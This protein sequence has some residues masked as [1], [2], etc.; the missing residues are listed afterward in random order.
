[1]LESAKLH[2]ES[3]R[4]PTYSTYKNHLDKIEGVR[5]S[6]TGVDKWADL[7]LDEVKMAEDIKHNLDGAK[8]KEEKEGLFRE[9]LGSKE[10]AKEFVLVDDIIDRV[11]YRVRNHISSKENYTILLSFCVVI[12]LYFIILLMQSDPA[13]SYSIESTLKNF[14]FT[15][16]SGT[17]E[18]DGSM[19]DSVDSGDDI[20]SW[21]QAIIAA[22]VASIHSIPM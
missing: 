17:A 15:P 9:K 18:Y 3:P 10:A 4:G 8:Y 6:S 11:R 7:N 5:R 2:G 20:I 22:Q 14:L 21:L 13:V 16:D 12:S 1:M 19:A